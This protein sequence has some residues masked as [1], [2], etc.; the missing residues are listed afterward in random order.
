MASKNI[1]S[2]I[3]FNDQ[4]MIES[5]LPGKLVTIFTIVD[6]VMIFVILGFISWIFDDKIG[7][8]VRNSYEC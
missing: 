3:W 8:E 4:D 5:T 2:K 7:V 6:V 1:S